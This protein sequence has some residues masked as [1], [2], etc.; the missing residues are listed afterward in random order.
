MGAVGCGTCRE[1]SLVAPPGRGHHSKVRSSR[2][3][4]TRP[5]P[6]GE[7]ASGASGQPGPQ[8]PHLENGAMRTPAPGGWEAQKRESALEAGGAMLQRQALAGSLSPPTAPVP[9]RETSR[10]LR[11]TPGGC[12][13]GLGAP[14]LRGS[15]GEPRPRSEPQ[16]LPQVCELRCESGPC[17]SPGRSPRVPVLQLHKDRAPGL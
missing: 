10:W 15:L 14:R 11:A 17:G 7:A 2:K 8:C 6:T 4:Q 12:P 3:F 16:R 5:R 13:K 1:T 9:Q